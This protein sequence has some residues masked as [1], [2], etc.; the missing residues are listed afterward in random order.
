MQVTRPD[1]PLTPEEEAELAKL[2][3][4]VET[5]IADGILSKTED[6]AIRA[7]ALAGRPGPELLRQELAMYRQLVTQKVNEGLLVA[8]KFD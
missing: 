4:L 3:I 6:Q 8:E 7:S 5:A 1:Q 2:K